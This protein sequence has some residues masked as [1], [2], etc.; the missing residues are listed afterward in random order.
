M[1]NKTII[2]IDFDHT[3][4]NTD[5]FVKNMNKP[6]KNLEYK[7][8]LYSDAEEFVSYAA[9]YGTPVLFSEGEVDFQWDKINKTELKKLFGENIKVYPS[10]TKMV[11]IKKFTNGSKVI[12]IDDK[13]E[14]VDTGLALGYKVIRVKRGK[15][16]ASDTKL[17]PAH[18]VDSLK[19]I[20]SKDL[21]KNI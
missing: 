2:L 9:R 1:N 10:Y 18:V 19:T 11:E 6:D 7:N 4:F 16:E 17:N 13:P 3:L 21:L 12:L 8:F 20:I 14:V 15:Y 5:E